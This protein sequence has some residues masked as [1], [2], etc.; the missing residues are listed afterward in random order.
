MVLSIAELQRCL[1][2]SSEPIAKRTR[3]I[4]AL[5]ALSENNEA[6]EALASGSLHRAQ[7]HYAHCCKQANSL[8][9][10]EN[11]PSA[12][13]RH[14][15]AYVLGQMQN[16]TA[17]PHLIRILEDTQEHPMVRHEA[18]EAL[19]ALATAEAVSYLEKYSNDAAQEVSD[20][21]KL[22]LD[23]VKWHQK[24][25]R[26]W[27]RFVFVLSVAALELMKSTL[28]TCPLT[29]PRLCTSVGTLQCCVRFFLMH[30]EACSSVTLLCLRFAR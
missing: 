1:L 6:V 26:S 30:R 13:L 4:Y 19:G 9:R 18:A 7:Q 28:C 25:R 3:A 22:A 16:A 12:L 2:D 10:K 14:E 27:M 23:S 5:R 29:L 17:F 15:I 24:Q 11:S 20:T 21:C 8:V